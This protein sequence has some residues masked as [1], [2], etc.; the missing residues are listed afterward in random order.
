MLQMTRH[1]CRTYTDLTEA[2]IAFLEEYTP[3]L[4]A[5]ANAEQADVFID[6][7]TSSGKSAIVVGEAK[8]TT[9]ASCYSGTILGMIINWKDEPA[10][11]RSFRLGVPTVG[12]KAVSMPENAQVVQTVDPLFFHGK[13]V[14]VLIYEKR[15]TQ[16]E[17]RFLR[18]PVEQEALFRH[19][20]GWLVERISEAV[21]LVDRDGMICDYNTAAQALYR[22]LGY[23]NDI[24]GMP[25]AHILPYLERDQD[26]VTELRKEVASGASIL[27]YHQVPLDREK[28]WFGV[29]IRDIT[30]LRRREQEAMLLSVSLRELKH[31]MKNNLQLLSSI[32]RDQGEK[33]AGTEARGALRDASVRLLSV[34]STLNE[35]VQLPGER[36]SLRHVL[37]DIRG[38]VSG[39]MLA[40]ARGI[41]IV[42]TGSD[43]AVPA[44]TGGSV[45]LVVNELV[46]NA[47]RHA[48][49]NGRKG[50]IE[51]NVDACS[52]SARISVRDDGVGMP[53]LLGGGGLGLNL[54]RT[55]VQEKLGG[56][57]SIRSGP[58]GTAV[59]F[60][61]FLL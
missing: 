36:V 18:L 13:L 28:V 4:Q 6:C 35:V 16:A 19:D 11:D 10:V 33:V 57:V 44:E 21:L 15:S 12:M 39:H 52:L 38:N 45:A 40:P 51:L 61:F 20:S 53:E 43:L 49:P 7:R 14:A 60:D 47:V 3:N 59:S 23:V 42:V 54:V 48:F 32:L 56:E 24:L 25:A 34:M 26:E 37:E 2:E 30:D 5:L 8:P 58:E 17:E 29:L 55:I 41:A 31:R 46:L 50:T 1:L 27:E 9:V 22:R